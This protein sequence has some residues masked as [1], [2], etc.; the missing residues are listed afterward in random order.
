MLAEIMKATATGSLHVFD[1]FEGLSE[2]R[3]ED[4]GGAIGHDQQEMIRAQFKSNYDEVAGRLA[5]YDF[6]R[7]YRG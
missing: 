6:I 4:A 3:P 2:F 7:F 5:K 1:S